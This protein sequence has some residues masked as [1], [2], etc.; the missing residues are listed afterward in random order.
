MKVIPVI[1]CGGGGA[2]LWPT[3][4]KSYPKQFSNLLGEKS[5]FQQT[6]SRFNSDHDSRFSDPIFLTNNDYRFNVEQHAEHIGIKPKLIM[7]EPEPLNTAPAILAATLKCYEEN[8]DSV[9]LVAPSDHAIS[10]L[11]LFKELLL[12]G[13]EELGNGKIITFGVKPT[14]PEPGYGYLEIEKT[15][16]K[17]THEVMKFIEKPSLDVASAMLNNGDFLWNSG[18]YL[19]KAKDMLEAFKAHAPDYIG[20]VTDALTNGQKDLNFFRF[21][22]N[23]WLNCKEMSIDYAVM[24]YSNNLFAIELD[25]GWSDLGGWDSV[26]HYLDKDGDGVARSDNAYSIDCKNT[27]LRSETENQVLVGI[28]LENIIAVTMQ[29]A[30]LVAH[31]NKAQEVKKVIST[32]KSEEKSQAEIFPKD[33]R[34]WGWFE[35]LVNSE[36]FQVKCLCVHPGASLSLQSHN[37]R[38]EHWIIVEGTAKIEIDEKVKCF[39]EGESTY[40]PLGSRHR[41]SNPG[42]INLVVIEVQIGSYLGEDDIQRFDDLYRRT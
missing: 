20:P 28:G 11:S 3:S 21:D 35:S 9:L 23:S 17:F 36:R 26:W 6:I 33:Y 14:Y 37:H 40:I 22:R 24:E 29:D 30:V 19:F 8:T 18:I 25:V 32:L 38:S 1:L 13:A 34:P 12:K 4:R 16:N 31:K 39:Y 27:L 2:R 5:L 41:L 15:K 7:V 42:K 10:N